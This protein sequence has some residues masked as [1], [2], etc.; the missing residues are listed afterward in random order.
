MSE[1]EAP[2]QVMAG[3]TTTVVPEEDGRLE[4]VDIVVPGGHD[5]NVDCGPPEIP[6]R[7]QHNADEDTTSSTRRSGNSNNTSNFVPGQEGQNTHPVDIVS[8]A[9]PHDHEPE[10]LSHH[11]L[12]PTLLGTN[13]DSGILPGKKARKTIKFNHDEGI[14]EDRQWNGKEWNG[15]SA[16]QEIEVLSESEVGHA[17]N[18]PEQQDRGTEPDS[19]RS[20]SNQGLAGTTSYI[21]NIGHR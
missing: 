11:T 18:H 4:L 16:A 21:S 7:D 13:I 17:D 1:A 20:P 3:A 12:L 5:G 6:D 9:P 10:Q 14:Q 15:N 2:C 8:S 19:V